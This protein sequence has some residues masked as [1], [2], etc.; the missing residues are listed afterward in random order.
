MKT[1]LTNSIIKNQKTLRIPWTTRVGKNLKVEF[2]SVWPNPFRSKPG[3]M[4]FLSVS[5][6]LKVGKIKTKFKIKFKTLTFSFT[7]ERYMKIVFFALK[8]NS[9]PSNR[10]IT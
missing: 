9:I 3:Q 8:Y 1:L 2:V 5:F 4:P 6:R 10:G 7:G